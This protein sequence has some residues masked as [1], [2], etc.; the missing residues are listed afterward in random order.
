MKN[1]ISKGYKQ[2]NDNDF[3]TTCSRAF[4]RLENNPNFPN[5]P[6]ALASLGKLVP[7]FSVAVINTGDRDRVKI[8]AKNDLRAD[9]EAALDVLADFVTEVS[10]G[11]RT[12]LLSSGF[13]LR[14]PRSEA[15]LGVI[16]ALEVTI[17][18]P[19]EATTRIKRVRGARAYIHRYTVDPV[20]PDSEWTS[21]VVTDLSYT[22]TGLLSKEKYVFQ[23][24]AVGFKG[25]EAFSP[26]VGR[27]IQ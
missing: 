25:Q 23:V 15:T 8:S 6:D 27:V 11:D 12:L 7:Q 26:M 10:Q 20:T 3:I 13:E 5:P 19:T 14:S 16:P 2:E 1:K 21:K 17:D 18:R 22:F 24:I 9:M 4:N